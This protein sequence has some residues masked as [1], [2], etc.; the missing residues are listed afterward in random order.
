LTVRWT[1]GKSEVFP[2]VAA[3]QL[4]VIRE[5]AGIIRTEKFKT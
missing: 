1:N 5:G 2:K 4:V 3:N